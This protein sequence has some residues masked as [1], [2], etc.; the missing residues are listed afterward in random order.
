MPYEVIKL[1]NC[2]DYTNEK[3]TI[4]ITIGDAIWDSA[5]SNWERGVYPT[6]SSL[7]KKGIFAITRK[8]KGSAMKEKIESIIAVLRKTLDELKDLRQEVRNDMPVIVTDEDYEDRRKTHQS[9]ISND[10]LSDLT[11]SDENIQQAIKSLG[12]TI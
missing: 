7:W 8:T 6:A 4:V 3:P 1:Q 9:E 5:F 12:Y 10:I 11:A 2:S